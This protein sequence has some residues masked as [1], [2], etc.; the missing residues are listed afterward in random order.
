MEEKD[1]REKTKEKAKVDVEIGERKRMRRG[2]EED[3][4]YRECDRK[5]RG[6]RRRKGRKDEIGGR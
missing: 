6:M 5:M 1:D 2:K 3:K 4:E